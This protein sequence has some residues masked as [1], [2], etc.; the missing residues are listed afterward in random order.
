MPLKSRQIAMVNSVNPWK[1]DNMS[2]VTMHYA[3]L[4]ESQ[5]TPNGTKVGIAP[6]KTQILPSLQP[7]FAKQ[8]IYLIEGY[9]Q[10]TKFEITGGKLLEEISEKKYMEMVK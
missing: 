5:H 4:A 8:G 6:V 1:M 10:G 3:P 2:G 9:P 7:V